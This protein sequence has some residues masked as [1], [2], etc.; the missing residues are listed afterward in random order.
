MSNENRYYI[1][2]EEHLLNT[3]EEKISLIQRLKQYLDLRNVSVLIGNGASIP[4]GAPKI[5]NVHG[6]VG[7]LQSSPYALSDEAAQNAALDLLDVLVPTDGPSIG[8]EP[9]LGLLADLQADYET[10]PKGTSILVNSSLVGPD[11]AQALEKLLKKWLYLKCRAIGIGTLD[12]R[13]SVHRELF[14]RFLLRPTSLPRLRVFTTNYDLLVEKAL[15][16]LGVWYFDGFLGTVERKLRTESYHYDLYFPGETTEGRV[17]RVD[18]VVQL[19]KLHGSINWRRDRDTRTLDVLI[20]HDVADDAVYAEVMVYPSPLKVTEMNGY[21]YAE[22]FRHFSA[23]IHQPQSVLFTIG[24]SFGDDHINRII[25]QALS[26][27]SFMLIVVLPSIPEPVVGTAP[28]RE[29]EIWRLINRV[30]SKRILV[31]TGGTA[32]P[33]GGFVTGAGTMQEF[34]REWM[35]DISELDIEGKVKDE[36]KRLLDTECEDEGEA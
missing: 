17:S 2:A 3:E 12:E 27:P 32:G 8:V 19:C 30:N 16:Q 9:L 4:L 33:D 25:Y 5:G 10:L 26:I 34:A 36:V 28:G 14:R 18:R 22:M 31:I 21:P 11:H 6:L 15:D 29:P 35:P 7:E 1:G 24:Y 13:L 23:T 20:E